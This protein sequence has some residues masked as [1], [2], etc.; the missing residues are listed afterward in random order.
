MFFSM[1]ADETM[2]NELAQEL[3]NYLQEISE[4]SGEPEQDARD[5][6]YFDQYWEEVDKRFPFA[7]FVAGKIA[8]FCLLRFDE[9]ESRFE[10]AE[11]TIKPEYRRKGYGSQAADKVKGFTLSVEKNPVIVTKT[12]QNHPY[13]AKFWEKQGFEFKECKDDKNVFVYGEI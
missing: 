3:Q 4:L 1:L 5:Y 7:F 13:S 11:F 9:A 8:G 10:I 12:L 2:K 6:P